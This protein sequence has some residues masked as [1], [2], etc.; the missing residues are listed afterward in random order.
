MSWSAERSEAHSEKIPE[1]KKPGY[2]RISINT[3]TRA[4]LEKY[5]I[6]LAEFRQP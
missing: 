6:Y 2:I 3:R 5:L 4:F 1:R